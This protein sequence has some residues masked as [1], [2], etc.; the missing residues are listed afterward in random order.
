MGA[1]ATDYVEKMWPL[2]YGH[3][4]AKKY[5]YPSEG[6]FNI[7][8]SAAGYLWDRAREAG[9]SYRSYGEFVNNGATTND[10]CFTFVPELQGHFDPWFRSF[11]V[12]YSDLARADRFISELHRFEREGDLPR[13]QILRL[14]NDHTAGT[15]T[16]KL[17]PRAFVA[18]NDLALG[19]VVEAVSRSRFWSSTAIFVVEDDAQDGPD[20]VDAHRTIAY[21]ISP[22]VRHGA[23]DSTL[24]STCSM[25]R[26]IELILRLKPMTQFDAAAAPM[27]NAFQA[28]PDA[29]PY[30]A[31]PARIDLQ[32]RNP[33]SAWGSELSAKMDFSREDAADDQL[34]NEVIWRS[35]KGP[36]SR[37]PAPTR[38]AFVLGRADADDSSDPE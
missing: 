37:M 27:S 22:F 3:N 1:Y 26:T 15:S 13:L 8:A 38:S 24:Y 23:I 12:D 14:P 36:D 17:T 21:V 11:D 9:I 32:E 2:S 10:P 20:H 29:R 25:L 4:S 16:N 7:A 34:L 18:E 28:Q 30:Q 19:R 6:R 35:I 5:T 33:K 31:E